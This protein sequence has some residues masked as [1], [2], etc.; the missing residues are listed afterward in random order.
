MRVSLYCCHLYL[1][2]LRRRAAFARATRIDRLALCQCEWLSIRCPSFLVKR[3]LYGSILA[4][5]NLDSPVVL[6]E[7]RSSN[8]DARPVDLL[9]DNL[10]AYCCRAVADRY[11]GNRRTI[12]NNE[13]FSILLRACRRRA[14]VSR[15]VHIRS[16]QRD[17]PCRSINGEDRSSQ[18]HNVCP[19]V[20]YTHKKD[21]SFFRTI[22]QRMLASFHTCHGEDTYLI[23]C[24]VNT[25]TLTEL[26]PIKL[27]CITIITCQRLNNNHCGR[28]ASRSKGNRT[29]TVQFQSFCV[30]DTTIGP[31]I[32]VVIATT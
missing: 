13:R 4:A 7:R 17:C 29:G 30:C 22:T 3:V 19:C 21:T 6:D 25:N 24:V 8:R 9:R 10:R 15:V 2:Y 27:R 16:C 18:S 5:L 28:S 26:N 1:S 14:A 31:S 23:I 32:L 20:L 12:F 11:C